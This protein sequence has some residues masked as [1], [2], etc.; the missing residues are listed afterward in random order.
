MCTQP[1]NFDSVLSVLPNAFEYFACCWSMNCW[2]FILSAMW[3]FL[4]FSKERWC[5]QY[6]PSKSTHR[7]GKTTY[8][9]LAISDPIRIRIFKNLNYPIRSVSMGCRSDP[10]RIRNLNMFHYPSD[11]YPIGY[12]SDTVYPILSDPRLISTWHGKRHLTTVCQLQFMLFTINFVSS[13]R[14]NT[15]TTTKF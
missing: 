6:Y 13:A 11:P 2:K 7:D 3:T 1:G 15:S 5:T 14:S 8:P 10:T 12:G 4:T 9:R